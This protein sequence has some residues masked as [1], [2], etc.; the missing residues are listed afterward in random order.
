MKHLIYMSKAIKNIKPSDINAILN[1]SV[2][3]NSENNICEMLIYKN[4]Y[5][6]QV[7]EGGE[8]VVWELYGR[9][10]QDKRHTEV[11]LMWF[12]D[13]EEKIFNDWSMGVCDPEVASKESLALNEFFIVS[14][15]YE[16]LP[17]FESFPA[18]LINAFASLKK[19]SS[20]N[21]SV[22]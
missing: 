12:E 8:E 3:F 11:E 18:V 15:F 5:F 21:S 22:H 13:T 14:A 17:D 6:M 1:T 16:R 20:D 4:G 19:N 7:L 10:E 9:I 2:N